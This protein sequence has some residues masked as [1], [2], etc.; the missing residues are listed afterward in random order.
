MDRAWMVERRKKLGLT[1]IEVARMAKISPN[2]LSQLE[3]GKR[4]GKGDV[5]LN[6][7]KTLGVPLEWFYRQDPSDSSRMEIGK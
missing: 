7:S 3:T 1:Q 6:L 2:Y 4:E 5:L